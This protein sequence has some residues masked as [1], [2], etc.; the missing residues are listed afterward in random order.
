M[1]IGEVE[2]A[3]TPTTIQ[4]PVLVLDATFKRTPR[5]TGP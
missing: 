3:A 5:R 2:M 1:R 4:S